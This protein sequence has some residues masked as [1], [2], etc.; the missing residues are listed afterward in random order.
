M[1]LMASNTNGQFYYEILENG[2]TVNG[3][4]YLVF[5]KAMFEYMTSMLSVQHCRLC[6]MHDNARPHIS[7]IVKN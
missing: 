5:M 2:E 6:L 7:K 1:W 3:D 4:R